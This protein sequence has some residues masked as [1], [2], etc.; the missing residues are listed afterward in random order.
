MFCS[1]LTAVKDAPTRLIAK[2]L[3]C[4]R[5]SCEECA[6][7]RRRE[8]RHLGK[9]GKPGLFI[10]LTSKPHPDR[11]ADE[12]AQRLVEAW[13]K[14]VRRAEAEARR[15]PRQRPE[16]YGVE[17]DPER[18]TF[19]QHGVAR[20]VR[21]QGEKLP[22]LAIFERTKSGEPHL[23]ILARAEWISQEWLSKTMQALHDSPIV[24]IERVTNTE[25][26][27]H[28][29]T[30]YCAKA[31]DHFQGTKRYWRSQDFEIE[32]EE[33]NKSSEEEPGAWHCHAQRI[34]QYIATM[35]TRGYFVIWERG[36]ALLYYA[37]GVA[38]WPP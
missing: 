28:Y 13:R 36:A 33:T 26:A 22:F 11:T 31:G 9:R 37:P 3:H 35:K 2:P 32:P 12:Q 15:D 29:V 8:L 34:D 17:L 4:R 19:D 30:K 24:W 14:L 20:Q 38:R 25:K 21:L 23:H 27:L 16:P 1:E 10:T 18:I 6:P 7:I 5:W